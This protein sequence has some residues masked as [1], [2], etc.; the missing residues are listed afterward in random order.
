LDNNRIIYALDR[1]FVITHELSTTP[2]EEL[3]L[4]DG[5]EGN[6]ESIKVNSVSDKFVFSLVTS[7]TLV[8]THATPWIVNIDG[9]G[10][11]QLA[12]TPTSSSPPSIPSA[13][14]SPD[15]KWILLREGKVTG[16]DPN[17]TYLSH[18]GGAG[19]HPTP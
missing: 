11:R 1:K 7:G 4:P 18:F 13:R 19:P 10:L 5:M 12:V 16:S 6:I 3:T 15:G 17:G 14:W 8:S 2:D 9:S